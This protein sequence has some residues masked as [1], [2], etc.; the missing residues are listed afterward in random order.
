MTQTVDLRAEARAL[1]AGGGGRPLAMRPDALRQIA[2]VARA[3]A[4]VLR[5]IADDRLAALGRGSVNVRGSVAVI[6]LRGVITP[7]GSL[8]SLLFGAAREQKPIIAVANTLAASAAYWVAAQADE[9]VVTPSGDVGSIGVYMV[10]ED[11]SSANAAFGVTPTYVAAGRYK[12]E[13]NPDEPLSDEARAAMQQSVDDL[14]DL[15]VADVAAGRGDSPAAV[16]AGYGEGRVLPA[17]RAVAAKLA[18]SIGSAEDTIA[19]FGRGRQ[20]GPRADASDGPEKMA[21]S[22]NPE[23]NGTTV[24]EEVRA[25]IAEVR[26]FG[27]P[28]TL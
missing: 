15:F 25:R 16:R 1:L 4:P 27:P 11:W 9:L 17:A 5:A 3:D 26:G 2:A 7:A 18:D 14:Y 28:V 22:D 20:A 6:P 19:R 21:A 12:V 24:P 8:L 10:H 23:P 13:G